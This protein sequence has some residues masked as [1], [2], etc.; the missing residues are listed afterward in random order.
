LETLV[1][2]RTADLT[3]AIES[4]QAEVQDRLRAEKALRESEEKFRLL[5]ENVPGIIYLCANDERYSMHFLND[6]V[7]QLTGYPKEDFIEDRISF[8][9]LFHPDDA[10]SIA[11]QVDKALAHRETYHLIYRIKHR[12]GRWVWVEEWGT[13][14]FRE[15]ELV[16]LEG[17]LSNIT[18]RKKA[19]E[20][21]QQAHEELE[22]RVE[23]RTQELAQVNQQLSSEIADR[24]QV[25]L[26]L[27]DSEQTLKQY[28]EAIPIGIFVARKDGSVY[29]VSRQGQELLGKGVGPLINPHF[30]TDIV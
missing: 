15:D 10:Q 26:A 29:Y 3:Y 14:V 2:Q 20:A 21:L 24:Q 8:V 13:G 22:Q 9:D 4:L 1:A 25:E 28:F 18:E 12:A 5:A 19:E 17:Y 23:A 30:H 6:A 7:E 27:R 11:P 16:Y